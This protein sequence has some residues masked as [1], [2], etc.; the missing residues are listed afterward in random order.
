MQKPAAT[1]SLKI[2]FDHSFILSSLLYTELHMLFP[3]SH[4]SLRPWDFTPTNRGLTLAFY[5]CRALLNRTINNTHKAKNQEHSDYQFA[6]FPF[7]NMR[8]RK[9]SINLLD[10]TFS[11]LMG[12]CWCL[13][14]WTHR[15]NSFW[16]TSRLR[17]YHM[18]RSC[19]LLAHYWFKKRKV[20]VH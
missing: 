19:Q 16:R 17:E 20:L 3:G 9:P 8:T 13:E 1:S 7:Q 5:T 10:F 14:C 11:F 6:S 15:G 2:L 12:K 18:R 4:H